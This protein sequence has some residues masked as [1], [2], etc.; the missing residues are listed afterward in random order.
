M[1]P[2]GNPHVKPQ[3]NLTRNYRA[4]PFPRKHPH[5]YAEGT[6]SPEPPQ[7]TRTHGK[8]GGCYIT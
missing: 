8:K 7:H 5:A 2:E 4:T 3:G 1:N 6:P